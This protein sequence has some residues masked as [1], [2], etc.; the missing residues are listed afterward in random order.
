MPRSETLSRA[1]VM[2]SSS[3]S[4]PTAEKMGRA[5]LETAA[6]LAL[7][8]TTQMEHELDSVWFGWLWVDSATAVH[9]IRDTQ[10]HVNHRTE[11]RIRSCIGLDS[12]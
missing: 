8:A 7:C 6:G 2:T 4:S 5:E 9:N 11:N 12:I 3:W 1:F 10:S